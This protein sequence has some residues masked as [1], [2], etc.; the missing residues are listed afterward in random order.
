M[1][2]ILFSLFSSLL[3]VAACK[4][5]SKDITQTATLP[6]AQEVLPIFQHWNLILGDGS[7][8]GQAVNFEDEDFFYT[9]KDNTSEWVVFKSPNAG[10]THGTSNNTRTEL[11]QLKKWSPMTNAKMSAK[12]KVMNVSTTGDPSVAST[13]SVVVGQIHSAD[14]HENEPLKIFYKKFPGHEKGSVFW[15]YEINT[16]GDDNSKRWDYSYPIWGYDFSVVATNEGAMPPEPKDGIALG[17]EFGYTVLIED[18]LMHLTFESEG[19]ETK[20]FTK[21]LITSEYAT[22]ENIPEQ[23]KML[24]VP[25]G[26]DGLERENAYADEGL[27]FKL[28]CYNQTNGKDPKVNQVWCSGAET[29]GGDLKKQYETGNYAEVWFKSASIEISDEAYSNAGYFEANDGLS[30]KTVVPHEVIPFMDK[31]KILMGD[32]T[33]EDDLTQ[34]EDKNFFYTVIDG[35]RRWV[36]YK[37]PNSGVTS[38]NSSNTRTELHEKREWIPEEGGKLSG[39]CKVMQVSVSGDASVAASYS[40]VVGQIHSGEGH[41]NEPLKIFYKKFPGHKKGSVFWNYEINTAGDDNSGRWDFSTAVWGHDM[42]V[43]GQSK[44]D[45]PPEP[46]DGIELGEEFSYEVN[47]YKGI[48]YLT[49]KSKGHD[50]KTFTKNLIQSEYVNK[51]DIPAQVQ[52]LFVSIGQDGT[53]R[54]SAYSGELGYFKQ[55]AY[56]QTNGKSPETNKVWCAGA[57]TY[58]GDITKQYENGCY[59]EVWFREATVGPGEPV[60]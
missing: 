49:F 33:R 54:P 12:L 4:N 31:F 10:N 6:K 51:S 42:S 19:N 36:V 7:N 34:F 18:G 15:N 39:T 43:I 1:N 48:M 3:L 46:E 2:K 26:Q 45:F 30:Q 14:G 9:A 58:G 32:G 17:E 22:T 25:I 52:Q 5:Q 16:A 20:T 55:G 44:E 60:D 24:F 29:F 27:F 56:N 23:V 38:P 57:E 41:E 8:V 28:G 13:Y 40:V 37:T 50:T 53:E 59:A 21:N 47:V 35:T 11:A